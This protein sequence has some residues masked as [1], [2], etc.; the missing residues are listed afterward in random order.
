M[1]C[2]S[3][4]QLQY[5]VHIGSADENTVIWVKCANIWSRKKERYGAES[6]EQL[7]MYE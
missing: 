5:T 1:S 6:R 3:V 4:L 2:Y 7:S